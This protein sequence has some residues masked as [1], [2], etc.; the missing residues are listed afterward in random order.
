M[1]DV[2]D[3]FHLN[4][5]RSASLQFSIL[6]RPIVIVAAFLWLGYAV[7][8]AFVLSVD[9]FDLFPW[10]RHFDFSMRHNPEA[11]KYL[12][13]MAAI[14]PE[15]DLILIGSSLASMFTPADLQKAYPNARAPWNIS[16]HGP[17]IEDRNIAMQEMIT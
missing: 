15:S 11:A 13:R 8:T 3:R 9:A 14:D 16:Y 10:G 2:I 5:V 12:F 4:V 6:R 17:D 1:T 7:T